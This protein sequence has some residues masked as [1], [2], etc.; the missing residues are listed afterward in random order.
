MLPN[1]PPPHPVHSTVQG[2]GR[3]RPPP[4]SACHA[5]SHTSEHAQNPPKIQL[6]TDQ[7]LKEPPSVK[8]QG[9][10]Q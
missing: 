7:I 4:G 5:C 3:V 1:P 2:G 6:K 9:K 10:E 8:F